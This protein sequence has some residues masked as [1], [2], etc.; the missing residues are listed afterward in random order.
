M[1]ES[2]ERRNSPRVK[3]TEPVDLFLN[4][5]LYK[6]TSSNV[7]DSGIFV[8]C[9][10]PDVYQVHDKLTLTFIAP[11]SKPVKRVGWVVRK[12]HKGIGVAYIGE[13]FI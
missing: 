2:K 7:S 5:R 12:A 1:I 3:Y 9:S 6:E 11:G 4:G 13:I 8:K 10:R